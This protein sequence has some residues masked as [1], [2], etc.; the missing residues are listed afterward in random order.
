MQRIV[1][2]NDIDRAQWSILVQNCETGTWFQT[3]E[4]FDFYVS[5]PNEM[6]PFAYGV[7]RDG[8][9]RAVCVGYVTREKNAFRQF[10]TRRAIIIGGPA[11]SDDTTNEEVEILLSTIRHQLSISKNNPIYVETRNFNDYS[12]W[13][14][15]FEAAGFAYQKHLNFHVDT[16]HLDAMQSRI[17]KHR[18]RYIRRSMRDGAKIVTNP[19][20]E[21]VREYYAILLNLYRKKVRTPL[22]SWM[23]FERLYCVENAHFFLVELDGA[24]VGG[25]TCVG[26]PNRTLYEWY[27]C[28]LDECRNDI[29]PLS[30]AIWNEMLYA[31]QNDYA[32]FDFMGAGMPGEPY[33]VRDFK[34]EFGG[35]L[36]EHGRFLCVNN[37]MLYKIGEL[38]V[39]W[40]KRK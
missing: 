8:E 25:V 28:G 18:W 6:M 14:S 26:L 13:R 19:T 5:L 12:R 17:G 40:L 21:Q 10:F 9:L 30:V 7:E 24:V 4:A 33:G 23:F 37:P 38:G 15:A 34:M 39:R 11:L 2:N 35:E 27:A 16:T 22:F 31:A 3:P 29:R 1:T 20:I 36:V 32:R